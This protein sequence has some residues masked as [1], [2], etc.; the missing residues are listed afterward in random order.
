MI[1]PGFVET[2]LT[3]KNEFKMPLLMSAERATK[4]IVRGMSKNKSLIVFPLSIY[5]LMKILRL[6]PKACVDFVNG[7]I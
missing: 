6:L 3:E 2:P 7:K 5:F 4:I 1:C